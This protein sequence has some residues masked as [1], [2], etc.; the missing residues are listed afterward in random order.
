MGEERLRWTVE[1]VIEAMTI[2]YG[3]LYHSWS[4][5]KAKS[6]NFLKFHFGINHKNGHRIFYWKNCDKNF[7]GPL[8]A[9]TEIW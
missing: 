8:K 9:K 5:R 7:N 6:E 4:C 2:S 1:M 3:K